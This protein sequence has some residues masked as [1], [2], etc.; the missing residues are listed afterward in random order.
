MTPIHSLLKNAL[1][2]PCLEITAKHRKEEKLEDPIRARKVQELL[3]VKK[4]MRD[5][6]NTDSGWPA[7]MLEIIAIATG[8]P[9]LMRT[10][11]TYFAPLCVLKIT[12]DGYAPGPKGTLLL[13]IHGSKYLYLATDGT[14]NKNYPPS[15][16]EAASDEEVENLLDSLSAEQIRSILVLPA[17]APYIQNLFEQQTE[18]VPEDEVSPEDV[19]LRDPSEP[20]R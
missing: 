1:L 5:N 12:S 9:E 4:R 15:H 19:V 17:F 13:C 16:C 20:R 14:A 7:E 10:E 6:L 8:Y 3:A 11:V 18:L 2:S